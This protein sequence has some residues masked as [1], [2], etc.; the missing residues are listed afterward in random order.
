MAHNQQVKKGDIHLSKG[1]SFDDGLW[2]TNIS[3]N[4]RTTS[5]HTENDSTYTVISIPKQEA[6]SERKDEY[7]FLFKVKD[8]NN[9]SLRLTEGVSFVFSGK[10]L[11]HRQSCNFPVNMKG[12]TFINFSSYG[13]KRL[14]SHI[15]KSFERNNDK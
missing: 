1:P 13:T 12:E 6:N 3:V 2:Q 4:A 15:K 5:F 10:L 8:K 7:S 14:F 11:T 9:I